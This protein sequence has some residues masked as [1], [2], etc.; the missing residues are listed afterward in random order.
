MKMIHYVFSALTTLKSFAASFS[1]S[2]LSGSSRPIEEPSGLT[3][4]FIGC[5]T[6][7][8][9]IATGMATQS[10]FKIASIS[11][12]RRSESKSSKLQKQFPSLV[13]VYDDNQD[14]LDRAVLIFLCV[15][16]KQATE[17]LRG[18]EFDDTRHSLVSLVVSTSQSIVHLAE[19]LSGLLTSFSIQS[20]SQLDVLAADS[21]L[22]SEK[23]SKMICLP[24]V[25]HHKG[26]CLHCTR[27]P[28][29]TL[30]ELFD[31]IGG[32]VHCDTEAELNTAMITCNVM[33]TFYGLMRGNRDWL[34]EKSQLSKAEAS[35]LVMKQYSG[36]MEDAMLGMEEADDEVVANRLDELIEE[37]T[38][39]GLN[40]QG[41]ANFVKLG[42]LEAQS[43]C[44]D[45]I[46]SRLNG[47]SDGSL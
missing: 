7:A 2:S 1:P 28:N 37:Q 31:S 30:D 25:S 38:T 12:S 32:V 42:G 27:S 5:G 3:I 24:S 18:L 46:L 15:L 34:L 8:A 26:A 35:M 13:D 19:P 23:V 47:E 33:G 43:K 36:M 16:P 6:I 14:I 45:A 20:T 4:G 44:M 39:G 41:L 21:R 17:V 11:V 10:S 9:S 22:P 40:E 29:P